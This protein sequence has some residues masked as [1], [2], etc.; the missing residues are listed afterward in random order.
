MAQKGV[1]ANDDDDNDD[2]DFKYS[3]ILQVFTGAKLARNH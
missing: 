2:D 1:F 3:F